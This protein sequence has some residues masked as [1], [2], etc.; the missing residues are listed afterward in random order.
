[1]KKKKREDE[2]ED[3]ENPTEVEE[4]VQQVSPK[5]PSKRVQKNHP[6]DQII[7][8]KDAGVE[9]R[10]KIHSPE[11][12]HLALLSTIE[13]NCFEEANKDEFWNKAMDEE[14]DQIEKNDT[15]ELVPRPKNKNVI[16]TKWVFRNKLNEDGQVT[17]NK[18]RL[19]CKGYAQ[20]E[21]ID[22]EETYAPVARMEAI[23]L[24]LAYACSKNVKVYQMDVKSSFLN[25]ELE[26]E[27]YIEQPEGFQLSE[28][29]DYVCKLKKALYGLK[30]APRAWYSRLDKYL[31]QAG[32]RK[33]SA[34]NNLYIKV[35]QGNILLIEVYVDDI[36]FGSDD[37]RLSQKF[38]KDMQS[39]FEMSL[40]GELSFFL[41]LQ[42]R[43]S[44][45]GIFI[46]Q[47][48]YIRE[49]LKRFGMEDCKPVITP[50]QTSCKLS[51]DD[52]SKS[53]DQRQYRSM[54]GKPTICDNIQ[55]RCNAG[56]WTGGTISS[57]TKGITCISS[58]EDLQISQRNIR[59]W[60]MVSKRKR[61]ITYCLHRCRL[62]RLY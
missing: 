23:C 5:T 13:P 38:A 58:K 22:F 3:E 60:I 30:Q 16:G 29:T 17:R 4:Q 59:V 10:R 35:S 54:I 19:V 40:L 8:N 28:N 53:T 15:W 62:G 12:T 55:T 33:G 34:D 46:S 49:M 24:L 21:G 43:Q 20:I 45:Q 57:S 51:K 44:N 7:G 32:F 50:M 48:K 1:M 52:D 18:A 47:T 2:D 26:E 6:S 39:E 9:T 41:G 11:Q 25:G 61:S 14:L 36:I 27:V 31:Q 37:D 56:S 42:I